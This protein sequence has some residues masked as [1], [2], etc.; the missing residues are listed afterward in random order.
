MAA[1]GQTRLT[2]KYFV[3]DRVLQHTIQKN[4]SVDDVF[5]CCGEEVMGHRKFRRLATRWLGLLNEKKKEKEKMMIQH[6]SRGT[7]NSA[8]H[9]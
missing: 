7:F 3:L 2:S 4:S 5:R 9:V 1:F 6:W 8:M